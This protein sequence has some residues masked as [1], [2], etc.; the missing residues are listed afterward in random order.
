MKA[1]APWLLRDSREPRA[2]CSSSLLLPERKLIRAPRPLTMPASMTSP[3]EPGGTWRRKSAVAEPLCGAPTLVAEA[4]R[5]G[6][7]AAT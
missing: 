4:T 2:F 6:R 5:S 3:A 7:T 1:A